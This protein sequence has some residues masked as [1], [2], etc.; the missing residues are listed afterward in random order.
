MRYAD[1]LVKIPFRVWLL[2]YRFNIF[3]LTKQTSS[4]LP[5][6]TTRHGVSQKLLVIRVVF[7]MTGN[8]SVNLIAPEDQSGPPQTRSRSLLIVGEWRCPAGDATVPQR[9]RQ[10]QS[11]HWITAILL[12]FL[13]DPS[14]IGFMVAALEEE[15][16]WHV[17]RPKAALETRTSEHVWHLETTRALQGLKKTF[18]QRHGPL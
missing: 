4:S 17:P 13:R 18:R 10:V 3:H 14:N 11:H 1:F 16:T 5:Y 9:P 12:N 6:P 8:G 2:F 7:Q 15:T